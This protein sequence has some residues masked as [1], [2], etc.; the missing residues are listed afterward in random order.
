M[1]IYTVAVSLHVYDDI[2]KDSIEQIVDTMLLESCE[3]Q[4]ILGYNILGITQ[5]RL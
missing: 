5:G 3:A 1:K 2:E 4:D